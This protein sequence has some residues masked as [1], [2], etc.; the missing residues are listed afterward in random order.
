MV[1]HYFRAG[2]TTF[3]DNHG[4]L[5]R[6]TKEPREAG[7]RLPALAPRSLLVLLWA[8]N[9][10]TVDFPLFIC[11]VKTVYL[12]HRLLLTLNGIILVKVSCND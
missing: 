11:V 4:A 7:I 10:T 2:D 3:R 5:K 1:M 12:P 8:S 9:F 6:K